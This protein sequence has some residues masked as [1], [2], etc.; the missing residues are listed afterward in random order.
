MST[1]DKW[2]AAMGF[3]GKQAAV[4]G[5]EVGLSNRTVVRRREEDSLTKTELLAMAAVRVGL[6]PWA[7]ERDEALVR[8]KTVYDVMG[9][10]SVPEPPPSS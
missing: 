7:P 6:E 3:N 8:L 9:A 2:M 10:S 5:E 4:A 1:F